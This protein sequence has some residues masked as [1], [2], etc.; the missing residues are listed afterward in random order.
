[1]KKVLII[2]YYWPPA[3]GPGVQRWLKFVKY[4]P[5]F[6]VEPIVYTPKNPSYPI[7]DN[8]M[9]E[10][11][12]EGVTIIQKPIREP[13]SWL[14]LLSR[15]RTQQLGTGLIDNPDKQSF[16]QKLAL[17][18]RGN[19]FIPDARVLW[20]NPT[21]KYLKKYI[22][23]EGID[24]IVTSGPPHSLH[25]IGMALKAHFSNEIRWFADFRD[26]WT[27]ISYH[28]KLRMGKRALKKHKRLEQQVLKTMDI[29]IVTSPT[30]MEDFSKISS[31]PIHLITNGFDD[32]KS[33]T[34]NKVNQFTIAHIGSL[35]T[36]RNPTVLWQCIHELIQEEKLPPDLKIQLIGNVSE[37]VRSSIVAIG[38]EKQLEL[39][40]Y[41]SHHKA[42]EYQDRASILVLINIDSPEN[43]AIVPGKLF[44]YLSTAKPIVAL[45]PEKS[46]VSYLIQDIANAHYFNYK[47]ITLIKSTLLS[48]Y[49]ACKAGGEYTV[50]ETI[51]KYHRK[52]LTEQLAILLKEET[53]PAV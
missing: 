14:S 34:S 28:H 5:Q 8:S 1:M 31:K 17:Y 43:K 13:Y 25:L 37:A 45:G 2:C 44:E 22:E 24:T 36:E 47:D 41:V 26:P 12:L 51:N 27:T 6:G 16:F 46:D 7:L 4:L 23:E 52:A 49:K 42:Q 53:P 3:G 32:R 48:L 10:E 9:M 29:G 21:V 11:I 15:K 38:L 20:V 19:F 50:N 40:G 18:I 39:L 30:T 35:L 33:K